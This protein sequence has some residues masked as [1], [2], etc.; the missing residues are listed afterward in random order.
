MP[1]ALGPRLPQRRGRVAGSVVRPWEAAFRM[2]LSQNPGRGKRGR[3]TRGAGRTLPA[4]VSRA[5]PA[6]QAPRL[7]SRGRG[8]WAGGRGTGRAPWGLACLRRPLPAPASLWRAPARSCCVAESP[9]PPAP[10]APARAQVL[11]PAWPPAPS[12]SGLWLQ[13][14]RLALSLTPSRPPVPGP[15]ASEATCFP[16]G[17]AA[18][19]RDDA[20]ADACCPAGPRAGV[21]GAAQGLVASSVLRPRVATAARSGPPP[22][23]G[24]RLTC[25][26]CP[27]PTS[28]RLKRLPKRR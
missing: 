13:K 3:F 20:G 5:S 22:A 27:Q 11:S 9:A 6:G 21:G 17:N 15:R 2:G 18:M 23:A 26:F 28:R 8:S 14:S 7:L 16:W 4:V 19:L 10:P 1:P 24:P 25:P 12:P